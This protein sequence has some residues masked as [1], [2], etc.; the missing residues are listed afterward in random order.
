MA[1]SSGSRSSQNGASQVKNSVRRKSKKSRK[2]KIIK[3]TILIIL[4]IV[5]V[6]AGI[7]V[8]PK[9]VNVMQLAKMQRVWQMRV[10]LIHLR[11]EKQQ[12]SMI[13]TVT[14]SVR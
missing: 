3:R 11:M 4:L 1:N 2:R 14:S 7:Y 13:R 10:Q 12:L 9:L 5:L 8:G 6:G